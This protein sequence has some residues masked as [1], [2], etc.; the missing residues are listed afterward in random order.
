MIEIIRPTVDLAASWWA[1]VDAFGGEPVHGSGYRHEDRDAL[2]DPAAFEVWVDWLASHEAPGADLP[3]GRVPCSYRWI[4]EDDRVVG[5]IAVRHVIDAVLVESGG[6]IGYAVEPGSR[7]RG[8]ARAGLAL[9][10]RLAASRGIDPVLIMC[11]HDN[12]A[13]ARTI[14]SVGGRFEDERGGLRRYWVATGAR[15]EPLGDGP[16]ETRLARLVTA[17]VGEVS[18]I[19][20]G[21]RQPNW[22]E[23]YPREDDVDALSSVSVPTPW[24]ARHI[25]RRSDGLVV[26]S[27]G[28]FGPPDADGW[29]EIGY[30][31]VESARGAGLMTDV[32]GSL[33]RAIE[34]RGHAES[35]AHT[36]PDN[37]E[38]QR[39]LARL[40][41]DHVGEDDEG[42][43]RWERPG[44]HASSGRS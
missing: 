36:L 21:R 12:L 16:V 42:Q 43:W 11:E 2:R 19:R 33:C 1:T 9:G 41:F 37:R 10:L 44:G 18:G 8:V 39:V 22:A 14:E 27:A 29:V 24:S 7:R 35:C 20:A 3:E 23:G 5:T 6:H 30:G 32:V 17:T 26:G 4:V 34:A 25:E 38:S 13:S 31:L 15:A 28:C 40:G